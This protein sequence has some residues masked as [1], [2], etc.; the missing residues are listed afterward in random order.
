[1][2]VVA[3][4]K[5]E[6]FNVCLSSTSGTR[7]SVQAIMPIANSQI[8]RITSALL[9]DLFSAGSTEVC[10][11][12]LSNILEQK[13]FFFSNIIRLYSAVFVL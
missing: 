6:K 13:L 12:F 5:A 9:N 11:I 3:P 10:I 8:V 1:M 4:C 7:S 2:P